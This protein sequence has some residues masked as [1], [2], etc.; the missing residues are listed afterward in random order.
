MSY[1]GGLL[2]RGAWRVVASTDLGV[3]EV[4]ASDII[5]ESSSEGSG[6]GNIKKEK[7]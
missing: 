2:H 4:S 6:G 1:K 3:E 7:L 5:P